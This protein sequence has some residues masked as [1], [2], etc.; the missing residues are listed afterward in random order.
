MSFY[1][2]TCEEFVDLT[3]SNAPAPGGGSVA[4]LAASLGAALGG[5]VCSLTTGKKKYAQYEEDIQRLM[6]S[7]KE[8][9]R[10]FFNIMDED[11]ENFLP[12]SKAYG[13]PSATEEE[14]EF[15][16]KELDRCLK[17]AVQAP[18][19]LL[20]TSCGSIPLF[21]ELT[22]KGSKLALSDVGCGIALIRSAISCAWLNI[23]INVNMIKDEQFAEDLRK[24]CTELVETGL[25]KCDEIYT[26]VDKAL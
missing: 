15:K 25:K 1:K 23:A 4:A 3:F 2:N 22:Q 17:L 6:A 5:M 16:A 7:L 14:K 20:K 13:L 21:E 19:K 10:E 18:V 26:L 9:T 24:E 8:L 12:L 11:V